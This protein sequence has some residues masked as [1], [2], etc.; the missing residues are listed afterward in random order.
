M[1]VDPETVTLRARLGSLPAA[2][3]RLW[4]ELAG[5]PTGF[6]LY[7][8]TALALRFEHR[9]S[10]DFDFF[11]NRRF[12]PGE[13]EAEAPFL[14]AAVRLQSAPNTL[15][16]SIDRGGPV[17]VSFFGGLALRRVR[18]PDVVE[19]VPALRVA[20]PLDLAATK[21]KVVQDRAE[22]KDYLDV[23]RLLEEGI[24]LDE[25]LGAARAVYGPSFNPLLSLKSL[26]YF[27]DGDLA[28]LPPEVQARLVDAVRRVDPARL[29]EIP[30]L[31]GGI[32]P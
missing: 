31:S 23:S 19:G 27:G 11:T 13:I 17:K 29:P 14:N 4:Q 9:R 28:T 30:P 15:V 25:M 16:C 2:Q 5:L 22:S 8:G 24:G 12:T 20:S 21:V 3:R 10:E 26:C 7:G 18:D 32:A 6:V 1:A